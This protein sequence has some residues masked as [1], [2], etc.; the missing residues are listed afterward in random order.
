MLPPS[1]HTKIHFTIIILGLI[2]P[3]YRDD[4]CDD[5][6][7]CTIFEMRDPLFACFCP[8]LDFSEKGQ[9]SP[10]LLAVEEKLQ[11]CC[12]FFIHYNIENKA[13]LRVEYSYV[14]GT[15]VLYKH[16]LM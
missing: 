12:Q 11:V 10:P 16:A 7:F 14:P 2:I 9:S 13:A 5:Y 6:L 15:Q 4:T 1:S 3:M 8:S